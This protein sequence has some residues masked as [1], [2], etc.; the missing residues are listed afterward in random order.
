V[1][2]WHIV[3]KWA[4]SS[5]LCRKSPTYFQLSVKNIITHT[6]EQ[7]DPLENLNHPLKSPL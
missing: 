1:I 2:L 6:A 7:N 4:S 3:K 5:T